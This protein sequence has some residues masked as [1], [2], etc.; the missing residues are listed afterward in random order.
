M[1]IH[2]RMPLSF[3]TPTH[4]LQPNFHEILRAGPK[5]KRGPLFAFWETAI[6]FTL[7]DE[8][9]RHSYL[10][11]VVRHQDILSML[12][13]LRVATPSQRAHVYH[14]LVFY[15]D[16]PYRKPYL[17]T[18]LWDHLFRLPVSSGHEI[19]ALHARID[20]IPTPYETLRDALIESA[21]SHSFLQY[22]TLS[23][24]KL[25]RTC[26]TAWNALFGLP[27]IK[28]HRKNR[29]AANQMRRGRVFNA[30]QRPTDAQTP[31]TRKPHDPA[32]RRS[33]VDVPKQQPT[34]SVS[35]L[36]L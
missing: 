26:L 32:P 6:A 15:G 9:A 20:A 2:S 34:A 1:K 23:T 28:T 12:T 31:N 16:E 30:G 21:Q 33:P 11:N 18:H 10:C 7:Q 36:L 14:A 24:T 4:L 19:L 22:N 25:D 13:I 17:H 35:V 3:V 5:S 29:K 27:D 8:S